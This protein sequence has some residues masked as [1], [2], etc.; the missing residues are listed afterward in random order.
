M[1]ARAE[2][3]ALAF[4]GGDSININA[5]VGRLSGE[6]EQQLLPS[7]PSLRAELGGAASIAGS[8]AAGAG[9]CSHQ[10][11]KRAAFRQYVLPL[12]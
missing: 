6:Q 1:Q 8:H 2:L 7:Q 5:A 9:C 10:V 11:A 4:H 12:P 3:G